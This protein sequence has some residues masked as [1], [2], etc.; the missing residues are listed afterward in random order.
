MAI[1]LKRMI[2][3]A[4]S[5]SYNANGQ[6][7]SYSQSSYTTP[8]GYGQQQAGYQAQQASYSQQP[9]YQQQTQQQS[10]APP[11]YPPQAAGSYGQPPASQYGQQ[12]GPPSYN[13]S[14]H[15]STP[16]FSHLAVLWFSNGHSYI[17]LTVDI[18]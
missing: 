12:G 1:A 8:A 5:L 14:N 7:A 2:C 6:P 10:Q 13:Q 9:G 11:A 15:Y 3:L 17:N 18:H 4:L 16:C